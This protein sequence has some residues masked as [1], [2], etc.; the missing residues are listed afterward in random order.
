MK[1]HWQLDIE[2]IQKL[3][4]GVGLHMKI[5]SLFCIVI[6]ALVLTSVTSMAHVGVVIYESTGAGKREMDTGH[7]GIIS[8]RLCAD[9]LRKV[10]RCNSQ[11]VK[12]VV[13]G[14]YANLIVGQNVDWLAVPLNLHFLGSDNYFD[15]PALVT[16]PISKE[17]YIQI[18]KRYRDDLPALSSGQLNEK[19]QPLSR[20]VDNGHEALIPGGRWTE[21][22]GVRQRRDATIL[23]VQT[24]EEEEINLFNHLLRDTNNKSY[25][26]ALANNCADFA[27]QL[28]RATFP[29]IKFPTP[30]ANPADVFWIYE[31]ATCGS[32][33]VS[34]L[35]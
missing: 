34:R 14:R 7:T 17:N 27:K 20:I 29:K 12:G 30:V 28:L 8:T 25:F 6:T 16:G 18:W 35:C 24:T 21:M 5:N 32:Q 23:L 19:L 10:R 33:G 1:F 3:N 26:S 4:H 13:I 15:A 31:Y 2:K 22:V 9:G 11:E